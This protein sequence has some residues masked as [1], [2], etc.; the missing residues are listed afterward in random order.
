M[1]TVTGP[2]AASA[3]ATAWSLTATQGVVLFIAGIVLGALIYALWIRKRDANSPGSLAAEKKLKDYRQTVHQHLMQTTEQV[4]QLGTDY[5]RLVEHLQ[6][7]IHELDTSTP[8][9]HKVV[10]HFPAAHHHPHDA[11]SEV[12]PKTYVDR[13]K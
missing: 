9:G 3:A 4:Q 5:Q 7:I 13:K 1:D 8:D 11:K 12:M 6:H 2:M 10:P